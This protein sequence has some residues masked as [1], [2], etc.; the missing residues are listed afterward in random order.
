MLGPDPAAAAGR[1]LRSLRRGIAPTARWARRLSRAPWAAGRGHRGSSCTEQGR[2]HSRVCRRLQASSVAV[3]DGRCLEPGVESRART[4]RDGQTAAVNAGS[5]VCSCKGV[6]YVETN[7]ACQWKDCSLGLSSLRLVNRL[8]SSFVVFCSFGHFGAST[9]QRTCL[10]H[11]GTRLS[12][13]LFCRSECSNPAPEP[14]YAKWQ[15]A[16]SLETGHHHV[17]VR[18]GVWMS[19]DDMVN[20]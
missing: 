9:L 13:P 10:V 14:H 7:W 16:V 15:T 20:S 4:K 19:E 11:T 17:M 6:C 18:I 2:I 1:C 8:A 3:L 12:A 5:Y